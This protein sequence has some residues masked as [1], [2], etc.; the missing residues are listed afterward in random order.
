MT[1]PILHARDLCYAYPER[2]AALDRVSF[3][4]AEGEAVGVVGPNGA[5][6][7]SL[8]LAL[9]GVLPARAASLSVAGLDPRDRAQRRRLPEQLGLVFQNSDDQLFNATV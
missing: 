5:G 4:V 8:F 3:D 2:P 7:T 1:A 6:K 9:A